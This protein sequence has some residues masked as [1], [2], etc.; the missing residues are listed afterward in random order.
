MNANFYYSV[1]SLPLVSFQYAQETINKK[2][3]F[4]FDIDSDHTQT[5]SERKEQERGG[6]VRHH[7]QLFITNSQ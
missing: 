4:S 6:K 3:L 1:V 7:N 2:T 5:H